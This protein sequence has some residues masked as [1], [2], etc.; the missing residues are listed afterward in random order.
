ML[1]ILQRRDACTVGSAHLLE[2]GPA[3]DAVG[4]QAQER[5]L[6]HVQLALRRQRSPE[7]L[8]VLHLRI[9]QKRGLDSLQ[10]DPTA[11]RAAARVCTGTLAEVTAFSGCSM[12]W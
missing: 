9:I 4:G 7:R 3:V 11:C 12:A 1:Q 8:K 2:L 10:A 5:V 6:G